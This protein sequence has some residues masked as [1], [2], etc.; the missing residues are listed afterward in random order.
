MFE[1]I[2]DRLPCFPWAPAFPGPAAD[3]PYMTSM[4]TRPLEGAL[5]D[6]ARDGFAV[7][8]ALRRDLL[9]ELRAAI[10]AQARELVPYR[11]EGVEAFF[12]GFHTYGL[13]GTELNALRTVLVER[14]TRELSVARTLHAAFH[15]TLTALVG[16][17]VVAQKTVNLVVQ[18][19]SDADQAPIHRC[20]QLH[21]E[22]VLWL[23]LVDVFRTRACS[24]C[25]TATA[26]DST[27]HGGRFV[28]AFAAHA[29]QRRL[30]VRFG[31]RAC[32]RPAR[33][34]LKV[35]A[36]KRRWSPQPALQEFVLAL[37]CEGIGDISTSSRLAV[38]RG[39]IRVRTPKFG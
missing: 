16:V 5:G 12:N 10:F 37:R 6:F 22:V 11:G 32:S 4:S 24:S 19:P 30:N 17:D 20:R 39:W 35:N 2:C 21:F 33:T 7:V 23:P 34:Q 13:G 36:E 8:P 28:R 25:P 29:A 18:P 9:D 27:A 3:K 15:D 31:G 14:M 1:R 26:K 38:E